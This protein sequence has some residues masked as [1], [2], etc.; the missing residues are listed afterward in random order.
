MTTKA[1][2]G[3]KIPNYWNKACRSAF[4]VFAACF[5]LAVQAQANGPTLTVDTRYRYENVSQGNALQDADASTWRTR[6]GVIT[7]WMHN[8]IRAG[9]EGE[10]VLEIGDDDFN[11]TING[12]TNF[13][14]VVD[15]QSIEVNQAFIEVK[16]IP[17]V[18]LKGGRFL[19]VLDNMR[20]IGHVG[21]R[22][23]N[24]TF[25][26]AT[27]VYKGL[28]N[29]LDVFYG[30]IG[31]VNRIFSDRSRI[32]NLETNVHLLHAKYAFAPFAA[33]T[34]YYYN[35]D[36][37][38][39]GAAN[40]SNE[41]IGGFLKG[42]Y[43]LGRGVGLGYRL[44]YAR[45]S[46]TGNSSLTYDADYVHAQPSVSFMGVTVTGGYELLGSDNGASF[47]T[48]LATGHIFNGFA[49]TFLATPATG[50]E[51]LYV[52][53]TYKLKGVSGPLAFLNGSLFKIQYHD[54]SSDV[55]GTDFGT[56]FDAY[57]KVPVKA[58]AKGFYVEAKYADFN[59]ETGSG[60]VDTEKFVVGVGYKSKFDLEEL[61]AMTGGR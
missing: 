12:K 16:A 21:W 35:M 20:Y 50:L 36:F 51:D 61:S 10:G 34:G 54:F 29:K 6:V 52:D 23:N 33:L 47:R 14:T 55:G 15:V 48:P 57:V 24:Q 56:E 59:A 13:S 17:G 18:T 43:K 40:L 45:Q 27:A 1:G 32:G 5:A 41:T 37:L 30:W 60:F 9:I 42:K 8:M 46:D 58:I 3:A 31:N 2:Q 49:D 19:K 7:P 53:V 38:D 28:D 11:N 44:E 22:Q 39:A 26:G 4:V 25:D